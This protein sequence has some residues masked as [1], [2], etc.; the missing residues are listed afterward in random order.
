[1]KIIQVTSSNQ[2]MV[3]QEVQ[4]ILSEGGL[5]VAPCDT[6]YGLLVDATDVN[7]VNKLIQFK[8]RPAGKPFSVFV[9]D[10]K[11]LEDNVKVSLTQKNTLN[12]LLPGPFTVVL[13]SK[14]KVSRLIESENGGLGVRFVNYSLTIQIV[15][16]FGKPVTATSA[17]LAGR[18]PHYSLNSFLGSLSESKKNL[19]D[20]VINAGQLSHNKPSTVLD[21]TSTTVKILR[22]GDISDKKVTL[23]TSKNENETKKIANKIFNLASKSVIDNKP[24]VFILKGELGAGKTIF[25]KGIAESLG[26]HNII[27]PTFTVYYEYEVKK[28]NRFKK[29]YHFDLYNIEE[30]EEFNHLGINSYLNSE[31]IL[32]F[33]W[34]EKVGDIYEDLKE[35][36]DLI[37]VEIKYVSEEKRL[38]MVRH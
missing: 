7:A 21:F 4:Q 19:I 22:E 5:V 6:V 24:P 33:E 13:P 15:K 10:M 30:P 1:M 3:I 2:K 20:L 26:I 29:L 14:G 32:L 38:L 36:T 34:G 35:K 23:F 11:M 16:K 17:N 8:N 28:S 31:N 27:S 12:N 37:F 25:V 9:S 18:S